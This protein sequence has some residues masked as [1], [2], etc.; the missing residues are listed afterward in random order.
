MTDLVWRMLGV[1]VDIEAKAGEDIPVSMRQMRTGVKQKMRLFIGS[2]PVIRGGK[3]Y[4]KNSG[5]TCFHA[6]EV[7]RRSVILMHSDCS[8]INVQ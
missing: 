5:L 8:S 1:P 4:K 6:S 7:K 2:G 3:T